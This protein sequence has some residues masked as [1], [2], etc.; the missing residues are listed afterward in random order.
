MAYVN[1]PSKAVL[2]AES[3]TITYQEGRNIIYALREVHIEIS[4]REFAGILAPVGWKP[5]DR[6]SAGS[7]G[8]EDHN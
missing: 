3:V 1:P 8:G 4:A 5:K 2:R 7:R 6:R